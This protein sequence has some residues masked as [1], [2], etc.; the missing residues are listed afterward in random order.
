VIGVVVATHGRLAEELLRAAGGIVGEMKEVEAVNL[1]TGA[2]PADCAE[3]LR[4]A[5]ERAD[6]GQGVL[7]LADLFGGT[8]CNL[9]LALVTGNVEVVTGANLPML[10]KL[11]TLRK[12]D[13]PLAEVAE[14]VA[15]YGRKNITVASE[16]LRERQRAHRGGGG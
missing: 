14:R 11:W 2:G 3:Q 10:M 6:R 9:A 8:P 16:M 13:R 7:V 1:D 15:E 5:V 12:E 4:G